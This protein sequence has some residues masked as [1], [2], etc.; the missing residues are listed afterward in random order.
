MQ[1]AA[2]AAALAVSS[3]SSLGYSLK[4]ASDSKKSSAPKKSSQ[5]SSSTKNYSK[6]SA[7]TSKSSGGTYAN[8][9][10]DNI[11]DPGCVRVGNSYYVVGTQRGGFDIFQSENLKDWRQVG[12]TGG[13]TCGACWAP[14]LHHIGGKF[15]L[16]YT[17]GNDFTSSVAVSDKVTGPYHT[18]LNKGVPGIDLSLYEHT[19]G[20]VYGFYNPI[21]R[22]A[23]MACCRLSKDLSKMEESK[24]LFS[25]PVPG[26]NQK[27]MTVEAPF[28]VRIGSTLVMIFSYNATGPNYAES[29]ATASSPFGP[30]KQS[31]KSILKPN[32]T[33]NGHA[34]IVRTPGQE[35]RNKGEYVLVYHGAGGNGNRN[36]CVDKMTIFSDGKGDIDVN[37]DYTP[38][39]VQKPVIT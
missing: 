25:G 27:E 15:Y 11:A 34:C 4:A 29:Y 10:L 30:W 36:L 39:G 37:V 7:S 23:I 19:D 38:P 22:G 24:D 20:R 5:S 1:V 8:P 2:I 14:D 9:V 16:A 3:M 6:T 21:R 13:L 35:K 32:N 33:G 12:S 18:I 31:N 17:D 26:L 28:V